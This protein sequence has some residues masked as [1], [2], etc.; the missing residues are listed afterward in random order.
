M[1]RFRDLAELLD[2]LHSQTYRNFEII[3]V[4]E[5][6]RE[7][8]EALEACVAEKGYTDTR[9]IF[10]SGPEGL[11]QARN[12]GIRAARGDI[13]NFLD[14]DAI[15]SPDWLANIV[16]TF[17]EDDSIIGVTGVASPLW[18][19]KA[20]A[21]FPEEFYWMMGCTAWSHLTEITE[22]RNVW[23]A[24]MSF[25]RD[26]F[27]DGCFFN[28]DEFGSSVAHEKGKPGLICDDTE[29]SLRIKQRTEKRLVCNPK[30]KIWHKVYAYRLKPGFIR[31]YA[32]QHAYS[33]AVIKRN[34]DDNGTGDIL[35]REHALL[36]QILL[37]L[38]PDTV[39]RFP[40]APRVS[41]RRLSVT[42]NVLLYSALGYF[43]ATFREGKG[44]K[45]RQI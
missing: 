20:L 39:V 23:G 15:P 35:S 19:D 38:I 43:T 1:E 2:S 32:Y 36:K 5:K 26:A 8:H 7:L 45:T 9:L 12:I 11:S 4:T 21:W 40:V 37:K 13:I 27:A 14:D 34:Y 29:L 33:K 16:K 30:I 31:R 42:A 25:T 28:E 22:V 24:D 10:N 17:A 3:L 41:W 18:R 44:I 6:S